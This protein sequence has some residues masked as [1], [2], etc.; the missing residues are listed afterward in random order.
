MTL[1]IDGMDQN[2]TIVP[3]F[4]QTV[5]DIESQFV[6]THLCRVHIH[7]ISLYCHIRWTPITSMIVFMWLHLL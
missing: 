4:K 6:K 1:Y 3:R 2:T 5:K 7:G